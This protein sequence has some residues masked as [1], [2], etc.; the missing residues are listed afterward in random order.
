MNLIDELDFVFHKTDM[1]D[2]ARLRYIYLFVCKKFS[3][4]TRFMYA[5][6]SMKKKIYETELDI[7]KIEEYEIVCYTQ[8]KILHDILDYYGY[9]SEIIREKGM[10]DYVHAYIVVTLGSRKIKLDPST[11]RDTARVKINASTL[12]FDMADD[13]LTFPN[14]LNKSDEIMKNLNLYNADLNKGNILANSFNTNDGFNSDI[15]FFQKFD[16][17]VASVNMAKELT[18]YDDVDYY[19]SYAI[20][21]MGLNDNGT[22]VKPAVFFNIDDPTMKDIINIILIEY[23][24]DI[25]M[26]YI[27][28]KVGE[29]Y[30]IR[31]IDSEEVI[32]KLS[33]YKNYVT[34]EYFLNAA[35]NGKKLI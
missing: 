23:S 31:P 17:I 18:R 3:Y 25:S 21:K 29:N 8:A 7:K 4:D 13:N 1:D 14:E 10:S 27:M 22:I 26:F 5:L 16:A 33:Y 35:M 15:N 34:D 32:D 19:L 28:E 12:G 11:K 20:K 2:F 30:Q 9:K 6:P 24:S